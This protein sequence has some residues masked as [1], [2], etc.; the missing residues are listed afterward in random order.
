MAPEHQATTLTS[1]SPTTSVALFVDRIQPAQACQPIT[2]GLPF[3]QGLLSDSCTMRLL[4]PDG[5]PATLQT[6]AL[7][8]WADG[9]V[10][11]LLLDFLARPGVQD[12]PYLLVVS[13]Q[14]NGAVPPGPRPIAITE[15]TGAFTVDTGAA[16]FHLDRAILRPF[17]Q[18]TTG[19]TNL[20]AP[21][22]SRCLLTDLKGRSGLPRIDRS[23][24]EARGPVRATLRFEGTWAGG[25]PCRFIARLS[26]FAGTGLV[27]LCLTAHNPNRARHPG[28]LWDLGDAGSMFFRELSI[29][30][31][32]AG[33]ELP[34]IRCAAEADQPIQTAPMSDLEIYQDS[35]GG[36][37][38]QSRNHVNRQGWVP[39]SHRGYR[40]RTGKDET[41]GLRASPIVALEGSSGSLAVAVPEFWQ[42]FPRA[43]AAQGPLLRVGLFPAQFGDPFELQGGEQ[44]THTVWLNFAPSGQSA[45]AALDWVHQLAA[46]RAEPAW[47][48]ASGSFPHLPVD[49]EPDARLE[50]YLA[51]VLASILKG[52]ETIDEYGWRNFG[53]VYAD[54]EAEHYQG[55]QPVISHYNNQYDLLHGT[56]LQYLRTGDPQWLGL[57][58]PLARHVRDIDIYHTQRDRTAYNGGLFWFTDH[59]LDAA[60]STHRTYSR[61]NRAANGGAYG[62]GPSASHT[63]TTG[64]RDYH[65]LTGD[66][67][68]RAAVLELADWVVNMDDGRQTILGLIDDGPTGLAS[69]TGNLDYHGPGRGSGNSITA[70]LDAWRL[71]GRQGYLEKAEELIRR[72]AHPADD[73]GSQDLL[74]VEKRWSYPRFLVALAD[75]LDLK[76]EAGQLD[77]MYAYARACLLHY[78]AWMIEHEKPYFDQ[79]DRLEYPTE[80]WAAQE[81]RK[82]NVLRLAA[83]HAG[84]PLS[85][86]LLRR[87]QELADRAWADLLRF[88]S[89]ASARAAAIFLSEGTRDRWFRTHAVGP[90]SAPP[91]SQDFGTPTAFFPQ[92]HRVFAQ[93]KTFSGLCRACLRLANPL[94]WWRYARTHCAGEGI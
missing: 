91:A 6:Q 83:S 86:R 26:F 10:R 31:S 4:D 51:E 11:W 85:S 15:S 46:A 82:A 29:E 61:H 62:G 50:G 88:D 67:G 45:S 22:S 81:F 79:A 34:R 18:V 87:G 12:G 9:S 75:Y 93:L 27:Q 33:S 21:D 42:Q 90:A 47:Y 71:S 68:A 3:P 16:L 55:P 60:T 1:G 2:V 23:E 77:S 65:Y 25:V 37:N 54:H 69:Y 49:S 5:E 43:I 32:L 35:S 13:P 28:G 38:W 8:R 24:V 76:A 92:K 66:P 40:V 41:A 74:D 39:C 72:C 7:E 57:A 80:A 52:R 94:R 63:F 17:T 19:G 64:L 58:D 20:L 84:E 53:D 56:L 14:E 30:L 36:E 78:A 73:I 89:R 48:A 59:Y 44:K 70:L